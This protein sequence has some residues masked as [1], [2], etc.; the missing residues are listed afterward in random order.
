MQLAQ[1]ANEALPD[2]SRGCRLP[3]MSTFTHTALG[4]HRQPG[5]PG[6]AV[7]VNVLLA[8]RPQLMQSFLG[9]TLFAD[10]DGTT[11]LQEKWTGLS[12]V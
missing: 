10:S 2:P 4:M 8:P 7:D 12:N 11:L 3:D 9:S 6:D 1:K 5:L